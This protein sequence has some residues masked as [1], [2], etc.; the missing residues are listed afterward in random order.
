MISV[1]YLVIT[2]EESLIL[3]ALL[4]KDNVMLQL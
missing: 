3:G 4:S 2:I 1:V